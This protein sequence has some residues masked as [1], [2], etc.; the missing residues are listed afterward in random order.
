MHDPLT[1]ASLQFY[2]EVHGLDVTALSA[3]L[4]ASPVPLQPS[5][6]YDMLADKTRVDTSK[7]SSSYRK[8]TDAE[9][10]DMWVRALLVPAAECSS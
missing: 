10:L 9:T 7:R 5:N 6:L 4:A 2:R 3:R 8:F 1:C